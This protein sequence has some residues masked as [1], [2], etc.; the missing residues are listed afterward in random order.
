MLAS[1]H[2]DAFFRNYEEMLIHY[3]KL[4]EE[5][6]VEIFA[7]GLEY[8]T[9]VKQYPNRW[10]NMI[11]SVRKVYSGKITYSANWYEEY[12]AVTFWDALDLIGV[13]A[14]FELKV[15]ENASLQELLEAWQ[16]IVANLQKV[17]QRYNK[18]IL[19]TE[20]GYNSFADAAMFP[21]KWQVE[22]TRPISF[23]HQADCYQAMF[24]TFSNQPWFYGLFVWR[25]Y[26]RP[27]LLPTYD[28]N[29]I[30]KPSESVLQQW[31]RKGAP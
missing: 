15:S 17:A 28:Y 4:C 30:G 22:Q 11:K 31:F 1:D 20:V 19:F 12:E 21:W 18:P 24:Q 7:I 2:W 25:F 6:G 9:L 5:E 14:Y 8:L 27:D 26:T 23:Q 16:P 13:G 29:P 3:G 10:R